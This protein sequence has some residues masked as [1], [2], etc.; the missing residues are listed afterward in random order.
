MAGTKR[1][2][3]RQAASR[4]RLKYLEPDTDDDYDYPGED[5]L[6]P[7]TELKPH[8]SSTSNSRRLVTR[9]ARPQTRSKAVSKSRKAARPR[10]KPVGAPRKLSR[11]WRDGSD[12]TSMYVGFKGPSDHK[13]PAW[14]SLPL[15]ILRQIFIYAS[16]PLLEQTGTA[17]GNAGWLIKVARTCRA[18]A[19]PA[20][21]AYYYAPPI[22]SELEPHLLLELMRLPKASQYID[23]NVKV[24]RLCLDVRRLAYKAHNRPIFDLSQL[25]AELPQLQHLEI[26][27]PKDRPPFRPLDVQSWYYPKMLFQVLE[28]SGQRLKTWRWSR[29]MIGTRNS[30]EMYNDMAMIHS[31]RAFEYLERLIVCSFDFNNSAEP[32]S[33]DGS[34]AILPGLAT[35]IAVLPNLRDLTFISCDV[36]ME[37]FLQRLPQRLQRLELTNCLE[38]TSDIL[39]QYLMTSGATLRELRL[40]HNTSLNLAFLTGLKANCPRLQ[41]LKMDLRYYSELVNSNDAE[42][43]YD[44]LLTAQDVPTWPATLRHIELVHL[45][46][47]SADAAQNLFRS[48]VD[49]ATDLPDLRYLVLQAH[50]NIA[51]RDRVGFRDQWIKRLQRVYLRKS[52]PPNPN[53]GSIRQ[54]KLYN[55]AKAGGRAP[56]SDA[57]EIAGGVHSDDGVQTGRR[58]PHVDIVPD[59]SG[60]DTDGFSDSSP[61]QCRATRRS[62]RLADNQALKFGPSSAD[63]K[64]AEPAQDDSDDWS[65]QPENHIQG[66]CEVVDIRID[67]QRPC[68]SQWTEGDFLDSEASGD[69]DWHEGVDIDAD[70]GYIC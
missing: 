58:I 69:E 47:W 52:D 30:V 42:P 28:Q 43:L 13:I 53:L 70:D 45:Q 5:D 64:E 51:W 56:M 63:E 41:I 57:V 22:H 9:A 66:L 55:Q 50:I 10:L 23:Y 12:N 21:E 11:R 46:R 27:H 18:F 38:V 49:G 3:S 36:V 60:G 54:F 67:N 8:I 24:R 62:G 15:E 44:E 61:D 17:S 16:S 20:F 48:L 2:S 68:E 19:L 7:Q 35:S 4:K 25:V 31:G 37:G 33:E 26:Q 14:T 6:E 40:D 1:R 34:D 29:D 59:K 65:R 39:N 32:Q